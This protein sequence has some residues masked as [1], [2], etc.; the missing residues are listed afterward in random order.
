MTRPD[1]PAPLRHPNRKELMPLTTVAEHKTERLE[2]LAADGTL[3]A[4]VAPRISKEK[5]L[6]L[7][8]VMTRIRVFDER[9]IKLQR[10]GRLGTYPQILGQEATQV[11]PALCLEPKDWL[12][13]TYRG[14]GA[15]FARGMK[16]RYS[17]LYWGGDDRGVKFPEGN[18]DLMFAIPVG[19]HMTQA[20]GLAWGE[21]LRG[22]KNVSIC[23]IGD[24]ASSKGDFHEALTFAGVHKLGMIMFI[25][26]NQWAISLGREAQCAAETLA[27]KA[28][29]YGAYGI[30]VDGNDAL[31]VYKAVCEAVARG[32]AGEGPTVIEA[33][34]YRMG[35]HTTA[36]DATRY[37]SNEEVAEWKA[38]DPLERFRKY[39]LKDGILDQNALDRIQKEAEEYVAEEIK[40]YEAF[41]KPN[42]LDMFAN[43]FATAPWPL[44]EQRAE[45]EEI[46]REKQSRNEIPELPPAE[47]RFP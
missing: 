4:S 33:I 17:L 8:T 27:Q 18:N 46:L 24:G 25:E 45:L 28:H 15:Y 42:P 16:L 40:E 34:T 30:Q 35:H 1:H 7:F 20:M 21:K 6:E 13:P 32:R 43:N 23:W 44:I 47:G 38:K 29:G 11:V 9:A 19:S 5:L 10:Q 26:N 39:L 14:Q 12:V 36:D 37:R 3:D 31:A 2:V 41:S 22:T